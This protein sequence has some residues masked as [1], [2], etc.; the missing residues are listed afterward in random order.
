MFAG[1]C[2]LQGPIYREALKALHA[3]EAYLPHFER[4]R[5]IFVFVNSPRQNLAPAAVA[6]GVDHAFLL[7]LLDQLLRWVI[8]DVQMT[9]EERRGALAHA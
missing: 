3:R 8:A 6:R 9:L 7:Q 5:P 1:L 2:V 4:R